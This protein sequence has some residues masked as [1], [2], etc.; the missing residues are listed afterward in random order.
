MILLLGEE[1][2]VGAPVLHGDAVPF[3]AHAVPRHGDG[4]V[5]VREGGVLQHRH[6]PQEGV[7]TLLSLG[8]GTFV[9][10]VEVLDLWDMYIFIISIYLYI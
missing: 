2:P 6:V 3:A 4:A 5:V 1:V 10:E 7:G 9:C 8:G